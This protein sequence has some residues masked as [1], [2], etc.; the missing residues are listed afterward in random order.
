M[1]ST[2][3]WI[4]RLIVKY[5]VA[6]KFRRAGNSVPAWKKL[7]DSFVKFQRIPKGSTINPVLINELPAEWVRVQSSHQEC[8]ILYLHGGAFVMGSPKTHRE[9]AARLSAETGTGLLVLD[10][11]LSPEHP[12]PAAIEDTI[13]AYD[14]LLEQGYAPERVVIGGDSA[15]GSL[16]IQTLLALRE[17]GKQLPV[18]GFCMSPPLDWVRFDGESYQTRARVDPWITEEMCRFTGGLYVGENDPATPLLN[19]LDMDLMGLPPLCIHTGDDE[20]LLSDSVRL[21]KHAQAAGVEVEFKIWTGMWHVF[22]TNAALVPE[23]R[24]SIAEISKFV[25]NHMHAGCSG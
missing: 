24:Q 18:A 21:V 3:S 2:Q 22:Q 12:F 19:P 17:N 9:L 6:P 8:A 11:R 14:W 7:M 13:S 5:Y 1:V 4:T 20:V 10:Y 16:T 15:G 25:M 23:A